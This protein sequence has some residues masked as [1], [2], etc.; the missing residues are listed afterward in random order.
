MFIEIF[1]FFVDVLEKSNMVPAFY[2]EQT[3]KFLET[4]YPI[5]I[6]SNMTIQEKIPYM[7][8]WY[9]WIECS[10]HLTIFMHEDTVRHTNARFPNDGY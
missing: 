7:V 9:W 5:E 3:K 1:L 2:V 6:D 10:R 8:E 4:Y